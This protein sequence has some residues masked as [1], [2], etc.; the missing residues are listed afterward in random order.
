MQGNLQALLVQV[1]KISV[2][3]I[4]NGSLGAI[5]V[6]AAGTTIITY[7]CRCPA[8]LQGKLSESS[9]LRSRRCRSA[10]VFGPANIHPHHNPSGHAHLRRGR[11]NPKTTRIRRLSFCLII[12]VG[13]AR[14]FVQ[15]KL[16]TVAS[17]HTEIF[18]QA[19]VLDPFKSRIGYWE[20]LVCIF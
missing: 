14:I 3:T 17:Q 9:E 6:T 7:Q 10:L 20:R 4:E 11:D 8:L 13:Q 12:N 16:E 18:V 2:W 19:I 15:S 5:T 1:C